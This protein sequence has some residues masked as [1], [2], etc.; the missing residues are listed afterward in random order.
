[1]QNNTEKYLKITKDFFF[2]YLQTNTIKENVFKK[3]K[4]NTIT[5][6]KTFKENISKFTA[7]AMHKYI[8]IN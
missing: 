1:M 6:S 5:L 3:M 2:V 8:I 4:L 7:S